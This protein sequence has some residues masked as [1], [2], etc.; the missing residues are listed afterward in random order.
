MSY[1]EDELLIKDFEKVYDHF[2]NKEMTEE[3]AS[4]II[5]FFRS[6]TYT[7]KMIPYGRKN[8]GIKRF[9]DRH[10]NPKFKYIGEFV[11]GEPKGQGILIN[12]NKL[13]VYVGE[14]PNRFYEEKNK[15]KCSCCDH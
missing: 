12:S 9:Y 5:K 2:L 1:L 7:N 3:N 6:R 4:K 8:L 14:F 11:D 13:E 15:S 10:D